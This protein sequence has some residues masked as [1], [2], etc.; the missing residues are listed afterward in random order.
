[1]QIGTN[2]IHLTYCTNIHPGESWD[3]VFANLK[4]YIPVLKS[5]LSPEKPFGIGLRLA[6]IAAQ[7][8]LEENKLAQFQSWLTAQNLYVFTLNGFPYGGFHHQ[9]VKDGVYAPDWSKLERLDYTIN[10]A[11][12]LA[13]LLPQDMEGGISTVPLSY[14]PWWK[15][16]RTAE[17]DIFQFSCLHLASLTAELINIR[18]QTGKLI[19]LDIEPEPDGLLENTAEVIDFF[20]NWLI[21]TSGAYLAKSLGISTQLAETQLLEHI[22]VCYDTCHFALEYED[23]AIVF[24]RFQ[25]AGIK[26][27]KIQLSAAIKVLL[28]A[29]REVLL[30]R[31]RP[32]AESTYLHQV[33]ERWADGS[34][35]HYPDLVTALP[36]LEQSKAK[37]WRTHFHVPIFV[38]DYQVLQSTQD[39]IIAVLQLLQANPV[40][41]HL[42]IETYTWDV[43][44]QEMKIDLLASIQREYEWVLQK[45]FVNQLQP[46]FTA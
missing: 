26:I 15:C 40:C 6:N 11:K 27:G 18:Q 7:E 37:E 33:I 14:K 44:P 5:R 34:L 45:G 23:P 1:M 16:D 22:R 41:Q 29:D 19:H 43:L 39:D 31:L 2:N 13:T 24:A 32:F 3:E 4:Q 36:H 9:V 42:E 21:P 12:V 20:T 30:S 8:L 46:A 28:P 25:D 38:S 10:L 17:S 35:H